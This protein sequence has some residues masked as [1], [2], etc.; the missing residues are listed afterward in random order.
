MFISLYH[1][2]KDSVTKDPDYLYNSVLN[3]TFSDKYIHVAS[4]PFDFSLTTEERFKYFE[5]L[6]YDTQN[7]KTPWTIKLKINAMVKS[8]RGTRLG[9]V[10]M[11]SENGFSKY[12]IVSYVMFDVVEMNEVVSDEDAFN[13]G[14]NDYMNESHSNPYN[15]NT[16]EFRSWIKGWRTAEGFFGKKI[17]IFNKYIYY[18]F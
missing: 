13:R 16:N 11:I 5:Q 9:D 6:Y 10:F 17:N 18:S 4:F 14:W 1:Q 8:A 3:N 15:Y 7:E 2:I 12:Y